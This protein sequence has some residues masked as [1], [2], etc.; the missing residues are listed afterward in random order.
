M[1]TDQFALSYSDGSFN[2]LGPDATLEQ[3]RAQRDADDKY[4]TDCG[5]LTDIVKVRVE[6]L[7]DVEIHRGKSHSGKKVCA[8]CGQEV[9]P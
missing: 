9:T 3:A 8:S 6:I 5:L 4:Q 2:L 7:E 1:G